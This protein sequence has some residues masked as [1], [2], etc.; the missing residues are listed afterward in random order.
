MWLKNLRAN[1]KQNVSMFSTHNKK[2]S[3]RSYVME[4]NQFLQRNMDIPF[5]GP[6]GAC[7]ISLVSTDRLILSFRLSVY[8]NSK[9]PIGCFVG[10]KTAFMTAAKI[11]TY[12]GSLLFYAPNSFPKSTA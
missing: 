12:T 4:S 10:Y 8:P 6:D 3:A 5:R 9:V 11:Q 1:R 2:L 7:L